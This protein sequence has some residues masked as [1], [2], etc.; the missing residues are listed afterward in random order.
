MTIS[1]PLLRSFEPKIR[2]AQKWNALFPAIALT[3]GLFILWDHWFTEMGVWGF[4]PTYITGFYIFSLPIEEWMF[5]ITVPFAC[6]FIYEVLNKFIKRDLF[7]SISRPLTLALIAGF[8][9]IAVFNHDK[10]YTATN[11]LFAAIVLGVHLLYFGN[12]KLG[13]FYLAYLVHLIPFFVVNGILTGS[14]IEEP[15]VWYNNAENLAIRIGTIPIEDMVY[16][17]SLLLMNI[18]I[19]EFILEKKRQPLTPKAYVKSSS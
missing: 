1:V 12:R 14:W 17:M 3:A 4:N 15:I 6:V 5:F 9:M 11:F 13:R 18:S 8:A 10:W 7:K 16:S 19:Y 2:F